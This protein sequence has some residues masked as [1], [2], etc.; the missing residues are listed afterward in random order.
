MPGVSLFQQLIDPAKWAA[1]FKDWRLFAGSFWVTIQ[2]AV[3]ALILA[4]AL[5][6][7]FGLMSTSHSRVLRV[8][9]RIYVEFFQ[10]TPLVLHIFALA[11]VA[12]FLGFRIADVGIGVLA[13][14][15]YTGAYVAEV[16][17]AGINAIP[18][19]QFEAASSQGFTYV[20]SMRYI[21]LP[22]TVRVVLPPLMNQVVNLIKN[23]S[24]MAMVAGGDLMNRVNDWSTSGAGG[25]AY[26]PAYLVCGVLYFILCFPLTVWARKY[27]EKL[28]QRDIQTTEA[29]EAAGEVGA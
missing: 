8:I 22:Q 24:V 21:I 5:G 2:V 28:K 19:G 10:D 15:I 13:V 20:Q 3:L 12:P 17:R 6:V 16:V 14:G 7:I 9:A 18:L 27:E 25:S 29:L 1:L 4:L 26:G 23:T 11:F